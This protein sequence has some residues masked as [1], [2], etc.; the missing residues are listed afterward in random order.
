MKLE[1]LS[2]V[3]ELLSSVAVVM[4]LIYLAVQTSQMS[5]QTELLTVQSRQTLEAMLATS[6]EGLLAADM[7]IIN[8]IVSNPVGW[9]NIDRP[10]AELTPV[11]QAQ[12]RNIYAGMFRVREFAWLQYK[13]GVL[14]EV[15]L[16]SYMAPMPRWIARASGQELWAWHSPG[17]DPDFVAYVNAMLEEN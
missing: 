11:E 4:T 3:A 14:D 9:A 7:E 13:N 8:T 1:K 12:A 10:W 5:A 2:V 6:R 15:A 17:F 16:K